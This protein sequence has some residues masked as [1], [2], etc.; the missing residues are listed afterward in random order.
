MFLKQYRLHLKCI[1]LYVVFQDC[2]S[3]LLSF[4]FDIATERPSFRLTGGSNP[5]EGRLQVYLLGQ[6]GNVCLIKDKHFKR[7]YDL[8]AQ[9][10]CSYLGVPPVV[11]HSMVPV[12]STSFESASAD[13]PVWLVNEEYD[14]L[15]CV[16]AYFYY[17]YPD[18]C[19]RQW[20]NK[21]S[22]S[23]VPYP[24]YVCDPEMNAAVI[25]NS[26]YNQ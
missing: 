12:S 19:V 25:C 2:F 26:K 22:S 5:Y 1:S 16:H 15:N 4:S 17:N 10:I 8:G 23:F 7:N 9:A 13:S 21:T 6:W 24:D 18:T 11:Q 3:S 14:G 20:G